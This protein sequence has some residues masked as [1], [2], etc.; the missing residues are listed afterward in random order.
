MLQHL[1]SVEVELLFGLLGCV[2]LCI[3]MKDGDIKVELSLSVSSD[4]VSQFV[5]SVAVTSCIE[6]LTPGE[7]ALQ[8]N[9]FG[10][11]EDCG[12]NFAH[13]VGCFEVICWWGVI[14]VSGIRYAPRLHNQWQFVS[15][16]P[17]WL[18]YTESD[19]I[20]LNSY[21]SV[22]GVHSHGLGPKVQTP[23][24]NHECRE[25]FHTLLVKC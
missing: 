23:F 15:G 25:Q 11:P 17:H 2:G 22:C 5:Q 14:F 10:I 20:S 12:Y 9:S 1:P 24:C 3:V 8:Q 6:Y 18:I 16:M 21:A 7:E 19:V 13:E 4:R